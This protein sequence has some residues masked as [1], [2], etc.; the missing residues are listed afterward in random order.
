VFPETLQTITTSAVPLVPLG[1]EIVNNIFGE[2]PVALD[3]ITLVLVAVRGKKRVVETLL[4]ATPILPSVTAALGNTAVCPQ[5]EEAKISNAKAICFMRTPKT[6]S[7][8][9]DCGRLQCPRVG[10]PLPPMPNSGLEQ[11]PQIVGKLESSP[12]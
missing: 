8:Y 2:I 1:G 9:P 12:G 5:R 3:T 10:I 6:D 7:L 4:A 11:P